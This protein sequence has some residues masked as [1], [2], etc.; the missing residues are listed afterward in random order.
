MPSGDNRPAKELAGEEV[1]GV[2]GKETRTP[3]SERKIILWRSAY[4]KPHS[5]I[6]V[7]IRENEFRRSRKSG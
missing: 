5:K 6:K 7:R 3:T 4:A 1:V 2:G